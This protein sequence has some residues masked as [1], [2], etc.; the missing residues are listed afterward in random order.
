[1]N[2]MDWITDVLFDVARFAEENSLPKTCET[3]I[4]AIKVAAIEASYNDSPAQYAKS[5][6]IPLFEGKP[7]SF[8][9]T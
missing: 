7:T 8:A 3:L 1:M 6:V 5:N 2:D 9:V 4:K